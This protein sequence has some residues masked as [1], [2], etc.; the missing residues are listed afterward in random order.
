MVI[1][2]SFSFNLKNLLEKSKIGLS[3]VPIKNVQQAL[4]TKT[5]TQ[6]LP[7]KK[8]IHITYNYKKKLTII[9]KP[10]NSESK[11]VILEAMAPCSPVP[12]FYNN[13]V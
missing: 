1:F 7:S 2:D 4:Y 8:R 11:I 13:I 10:I 5:F 6:H 9:V 12:L 3:I